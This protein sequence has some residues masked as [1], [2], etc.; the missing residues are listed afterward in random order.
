ME[1]F[2][3]SFISRKGLQAATKVHF[4]MGERGNAFIPETSGDEC[5]M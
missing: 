2:K 1:D 3:D 4:Q 5:K